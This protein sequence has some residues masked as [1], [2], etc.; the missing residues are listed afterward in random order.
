MEITISDHGS[1][2][3]VSVGSSSGYYQKKRVSTKFND[4]F[5]EL[6]DNKE[7]IFRIEDYNDVVSPDMSSMSEL[8]DAVTTMIS[9]ATESGGG[10]TPGTSPLG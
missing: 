8:I 4:P 6:F 1:L 9:T 2:I 7:R 5:F 10:G 3:R